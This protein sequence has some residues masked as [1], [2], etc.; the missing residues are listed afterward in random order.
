MHGG[1]NS[2]PSFLC[3]P[4]PLVLKEEQGSF[5]PDG[6]FGNIWRHFLVVRTGEEVLLASSGREQ[7]CR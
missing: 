7:E 3:L 5:A 6:T 1:Q 2:N 4:S